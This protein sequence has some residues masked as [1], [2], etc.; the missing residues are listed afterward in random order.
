MSGFVSTAHVAP[1]GTL[2]NDG[3]FPDIEMADFA[4]VMQIG[5]DITP[6]RQTQVLAN[7]IIAINSRLASIRNDETTLAEIPAPRVNDVSAKITLY[8][9]AVYCTAKA[10]LLEDFNRYDIVKKDPQRH[11]DTTE[12][13]SSDNRRRAVHAVSL[14]LGEKSANR[15][16]SI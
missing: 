13:A 3:F 14:L 9:E 2:M 1:T 6:A 7:A 12:S 10:A 11:I 16:F 8:L 15:V 5:Q 4:K